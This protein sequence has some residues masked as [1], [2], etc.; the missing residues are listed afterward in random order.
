MKRKA[1]LLSSSGAGVNSL[2]HALA[3]Y[4]NVYNKGGRIGIYTRD[5]RAAIIEKFRSKRERRVWVKKIRYGCR[6]NL[7]DRR[8]RVKGR[9]VKMTPEQL[10]EIEKEKA[11]AENSN[12]NAHSSKK[13]KASPSNGTSGTT[14]S[15]SNDNSGMVVSSSDE[16]D[17]DDLN[18]YMNHIN[19]ISKLNN[20]NVSKILNVDD[21]QNGKRG[22][23]EIDGTDM[24]GSSFPEEKYHRVRR[25]TIG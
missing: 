15:S 10:A 16:E 24:A 9:F 13:K 22:F 19:Q 3:K 5:E 25:Y 2:P 8:M 4:A 14:G 18:S 21:F 1:D 20:G 23:D 17:E 12:G 11:N 7:A 6:K